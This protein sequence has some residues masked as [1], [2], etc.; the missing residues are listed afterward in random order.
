QLFSA[1]YHHQTNGVVERFNR[2]LEGRLR[3]AIEDPADWDNALEQSLFAY[4]TTSHSATKRTPYEVVYGMC[5][6]LGVDAQLGL[7]APQIGESPQAIR[8]EVKDSIQVST[9]QYK[10]HYDKANRVK[11]RD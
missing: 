8:Q 5:P 6:R 3:T 1:V 4:R 2:T 11:G 7:N 9:R 10:S